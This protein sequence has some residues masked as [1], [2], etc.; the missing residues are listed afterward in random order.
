LIIKRKEL[1]ER[2]DLRIGRVPWEVRARM[3]TIRT[4]LILM[5][6]ARSRIPQ[7]QDSQRHSSKTMAVNRMIRLAHSVID[8]MSLLT[9]NLSTFTS[10]KNAQC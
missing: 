3:S 2:L 5:E 10:G 4:L 8:T 7:N 9:R 1:K 6:R